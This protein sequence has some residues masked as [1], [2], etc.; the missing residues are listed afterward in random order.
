LKKHPAPFR[1]TAIELYGCA[2]SCAYPG[3]GKPL[4]RTLDT[5]RVLDSQI[6]HIC[7][8]SEGGPRWNGEMSA[9]EN[10]GLNNL[11]ILCLTH[12]YEIDQEQLADQYPVPMLKEWK[13]SQLAA[14]EAAVAT[15]G[16]DVGYQLTDDEAEEVINRSEGT[17]TIILKADTINLG[18][19]G[20]QALA[21]A[22]GGGAALGSGVVIAGDGGDVE[23]RIGLDGQPGQSHGSGGGGGGVLLPGTVQNPAHLAGLEGVGYIAGFDGDDGGD[24][25]FSSGDTLITAS[26]GQRGLCVPGP[27]STSDQLAESAL[28]PVNYAEIFDGLASIVGGAWRYIAVLNLP[29]TEIFHLFTVVEAGDVA[30]GVYSLTVEVCNPSGELRAR[31]RPALVIE[32]PGK[33]VRIPAAFSLDFSCGLVG[34]DEAGA[35]RL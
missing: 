1:S 6:A 7:A 2:I 15:A 5:G 21:S 12:A 20:G 27:R 10:R 3:C 13:Q 4:Y 17:T 32:T 11:V 22:G 23:V 31:A 34:V 24:T 9:D 18:G 35:G 14:Y 8:R 16:H 30:A 25:T 29:C 33:L 26:A 19:S 28:L